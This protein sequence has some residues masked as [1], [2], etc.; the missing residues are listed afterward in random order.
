MAGYSQLTFGKVARLLDAFEQSH[1][2]AE[3]IDK[4]IANPD[5]LV[6]MYNAILPDITSPPP[7]WWRTPQQQIA[8]ARNLWPGIRIPRPP[9]EFTRAT[10]SEVLLLVVPELPSWLWS[11]VYMSR[12]TAKII[13]QHMRFDSDHL[14]HTTGKIRYTKPT[15]V[16]FD[17][18]AHHGVSTELLVNRPDMAAEEAFSALIQ[19]PQMA[20]SAKLERGNFAMNLAGYQLKFDRNFSHTPYIIVG[21]DAK[22]TPHYTMR[23]EAHR[24]DAPMAMPSPTVRPVH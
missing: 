18:Y 22:R 2:T 1:F 7:E 9:K 4:I 12:D 8:T 19:F 6:K 5:L 14:R 23:L 13:W 20:Y 16:A 17:L 11:R 10:V 24:A 3:N 15:W 21:Y